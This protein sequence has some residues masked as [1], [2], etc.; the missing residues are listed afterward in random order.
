[1]ERGIIHFLTHAQQVIYVNLFFSHRP[2]SHSQCNA[3]THTAYRRR[4]HEE[5]CHDDAQ[6]QQYEEEGNDKLSAG[7][8]EARFLRTDLLLAACQD[9]GD[10]VCLMVTWQNTVRPTGVLLYLYSDTVST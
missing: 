6:L 8:H 7:R 9:P 2:L 1:M 4:L 10:A 3:N 5:E